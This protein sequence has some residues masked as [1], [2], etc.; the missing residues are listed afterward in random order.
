MSWDAAVVFMLAA[1]GFTL[2]VVVVGV[3]NEDVFVYPSLVL[4]CFCLCLAFQHVEMIAG[5]C[6]FKG[7]V[8]L[9]T[10]FFSGSLYCVLA[11][12]NDDQPLLDVAFPDVTA[13]CRGYVVVHE[14]VGPS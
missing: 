2:C 8:I 13:R 6:Y 3:G 12:A 5:K 4:P 9:H 11:D 7:G 14:I 1:L 10:V